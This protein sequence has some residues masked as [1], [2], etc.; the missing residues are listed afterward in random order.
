MAVHLP[1][2]Y[3][4]YE[5]EIRKRNQDKND[6]HGSVNGIFGGEITCCVIGTIRRN[7]LALM[8]SQIPHIPHPHHSPPHTNSAPSAQQISS[9]VSV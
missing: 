7:H 2:M 9:C 6:M 8:L 3:Q 4:S 5:K 1:F